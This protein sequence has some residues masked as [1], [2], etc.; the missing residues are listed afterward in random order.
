MKNFIFINDTSTQN[1]WGCHSTTFHFKNFFLNNGFIQKYVLKLNTLHNW[2][3]THTQLESFDLLDIDF[4]IV[5]GEGS[6][7]DKQPKGL[8]MIKSI[9]FLKQ[10]KPELK[11]LFLNS[12]FDLSTPQMTNE[13]N[14]LK[15]LVDIFAARE[16]I[17]LSTLNNHNL[18]P[19]IL[20]PDFLYEKINLNHEQTEDYIV[21][22][23][24]SNYYRGDRP[25]YDA[26]KTYTNLVNNIPHK[27]ILYSSDNSDVNFMS[28]VAK[29]TN[30]PHIT[31][32]SHNWE[33]AFDVLSNAKLSISGRYHPSIMSLCGL[34]PSY[35]ISANNCKMEGTRNYFYNSSQNFSNSHNIHNDIPKIVDWVESTLLN[36]ETSVN[37]IKYKLADVDMLLKNSK[38]TILSVLS[39]DNTK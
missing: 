28:Q 2:A 25:T 6:I 18:S 36:Y 3:S 31:I 7:Y 10:K 32:N 14:S 9:K 11:I 8:N 33:K 4:V 23:G 16:D 39:F 30:S 38:S 27:V 29:N 24:N 26:I 17:S 34:T 1:N 37:H 13:L 35:F 22:G 5:N 20:Q 19:N 15:G 21:I 12:T